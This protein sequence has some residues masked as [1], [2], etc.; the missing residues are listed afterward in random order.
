[1]TLTENWN[2]YNMILKF[3][4]DEKN[5]TGECVHLVFFGRLKRALSI[6]LFQIDYARKP[7]Y[8][9]TNAWLISA[10]TANTF[11]IQ[12]MKAIISFNLTP[13]EQEISTIIKLGAFCM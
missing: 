9:I 1:M 6:N 8:C 5:S 12:Y 11:C 4:N 10:L 13:K 3:L 7:L 2:K